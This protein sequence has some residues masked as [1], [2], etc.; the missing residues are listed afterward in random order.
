MLLLV[1]DD[2]EILSS[3]T[4][5]LQMS[6]YDVISC[7]SPLEAIEIFSQHKQQI[8]TLITDFRMPEMDGLQLIKTL[9]KEKPN[10]N[11]ILCSGYMPD[12]VPEHITTINKPINIDFLFS[13]IE[14][15]L[16]YE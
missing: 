13:A 4:A 11:T 14:R 9:R 7:S 10:L 12:Q 8:T 3:Y 15:E 5:L 16:T 1:D 6:G 2:R